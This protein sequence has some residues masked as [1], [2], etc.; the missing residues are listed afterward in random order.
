MS[1]ITQNINTLTQNVRTM[2]Q[3][4]DTMIGMLQKL[5]FGTN[6]ISSSNML[7]QYVNKNERNQVDQDNKQDKETKYLKDD[8]I[9]II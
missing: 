4:Q 9:T 6:H 1:T 2:T 7:D 8:Q 3:N 5:R